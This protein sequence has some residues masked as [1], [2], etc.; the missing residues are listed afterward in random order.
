[1]AIRREVNVD[2]GTIVMARRS[3]I[4]NPPDTGGIIV[5]N[6]VAQND[7]ENDRTPQNIQ[8]DMSELV[9]TIDDDIDTRLAVPLLGCGLALRHL[10]LERLKLTKIL[11]ED[12]SATLTSPEGRH[13]RSL[14]GAVDLE[15]LKMMNHSTSPRNHPSLPR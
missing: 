7:E 8:L 11:A 2:G 14:R 15:S 9:I 1:M 4:T 10:K 13:H 5:M 6:N 3:A 12:S